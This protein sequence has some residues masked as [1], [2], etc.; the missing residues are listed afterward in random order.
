MGRAIRL[1]ALLAIASLSIGCSRDDGP[2]DGARFLVLV[3]PGQGQ[4]EVEAAVGEVIDAATRVEPL[5]ADLT[6]RPLPE[7]MRR[8]FR[9]LTRWIS[10]ENPWQVAARILEAGGFE[11]VEPDLDDAT[12]RSDIEGVAQLSCFGDE[13]VPAPSE[14]GWALVRLQVPEAWALPPAPGGSGQGQGVRVCH[15]DTGWAE[16]VDLD[17]DRLDLASAWN[18]LDANDDAEDP[19]DY[20]FPLA[21]RGHG[22]A[23]GSVIMSAGGVQP[24]GNTTPPGEITGVAPAATL[25]P[26]RTVKSVVQLFDS[27]VAAAV[28]IAVA[29]ECDVV[30]MSLGGRAFFGLEDAIDFAVSQGL[31]IVAAAGNCVGSVVAPAVYPETIAVAASNAEDEP[32]HGSSHGEALTIAAPGEDVH[33]ARR[34]QPNEALDQVGPS[35]GTSYATA[36]L[37]GAAAL[38][39][40]FHGHTA[41]EQARAPGE[42]V[43]DVFAR[44]VQ[45]AAVPPPGWDTEEYGPGILDVK[46]LLQYPLVLPPTPGAPMVSRP[47]SAELG[48]IGILARTLDRPLAAVRSDLVRQFGQEILEPGVQKV[49]LPELTYLAL[50]QPRQL[51][52]LLA[53]RPGAPGGA[54]DATAGLELSEEVASRLR[55]QRENQ[56]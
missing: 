23:T 6:S 29:S 45:A 19:L 30:S 38:W 26:L 49:V 32:W 40:A 35:D 36:E 10:D 8:S 13:G 5:F 41:V 53:R 9:V 50:R 37:A 51:E 20:D 43:Q 21:S 31:I 55:S 2:Y 7:R 16:H 3:A 27:D 14:R 47:S 44:A 42:R 15:P 39:L 12:V 56:P 52:A 34:D 33:R 22:T 18:V 1:A 17:A 28:L 24:D 25:V 4:A 46:K 11:R 54:A 48:E